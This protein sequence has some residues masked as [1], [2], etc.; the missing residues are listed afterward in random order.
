VDKNIFIFLLVPPSGGMGVSL[1][2]TFLV[3]I[4]ENG[5]CHH[6]LELL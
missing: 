3:I 6:S 1:E 5:D 2:K 4:Q